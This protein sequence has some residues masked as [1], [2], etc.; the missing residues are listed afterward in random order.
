MHV[1]S[2]FAIS[3]FTLV[4]KYVKRFPVWGTGIL[5]AYSELI[6]IILTC[7]VPAIW[8]RR[9]A[10]KSSKVVSEPHAQETLSWPASIH[11]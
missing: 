1:I 10:D 8:S 4:Q 9:M 11:T 6:G 5:G 7:D 2:Y 3:F